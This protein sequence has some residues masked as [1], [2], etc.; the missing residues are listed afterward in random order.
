[1]C[2]A[3]IFDKTGFIGTHLAQLFDRPIRVHIFGQ[4]CI[5]I[6]F[7]LCRRPYKLT[8]KESKKEPD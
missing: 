2:V 7:C 1:M 8:T 5:I 4:P 3:L 6:D